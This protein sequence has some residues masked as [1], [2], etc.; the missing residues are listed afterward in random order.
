MLYYGAMRIEQQPYCKYHRHT[1]SYRLWKQ[2]TEQLIAALEMQTRI[3]VSGLAF[4]IDSIAHKSAL[5]YGLNT[6]GVLGH[7]MDS[8]Y[9]SQNKSLAKDMLAQG[10]LLTEFRKKYKTR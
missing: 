6:V 9:P 1:P 2:V 4:G 10:G 5:Q 8:I 7:G 3:V